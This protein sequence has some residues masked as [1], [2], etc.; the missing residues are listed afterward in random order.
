MTSCLPFIAGALGVAAACG[1]AILLGLTGIE[2]PSPV[3]LI[4]G[5]AGYLG[6]F[7]ATGW[8]I[9]RNAA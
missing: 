9:T 4:L 1:I 2:L 7:V 6:P 8:W 3:G 5:G